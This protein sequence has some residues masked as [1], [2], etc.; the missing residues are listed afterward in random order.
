MV[1]SGCQATFQAVELLL[2]CAARQQPLCR[3]LHLGEDAVGIVCEHLDHH[4][5]TERGNAKV[6]TAHLEHW[7]TKESDA[8]MAR[9]VI[10]GEFGKELCTD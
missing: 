2:A 6:V 1:I 8:R 9:R 4:R 10:E 3:A 7:K 5:E